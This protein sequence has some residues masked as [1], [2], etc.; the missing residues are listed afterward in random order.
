MQND[1]DLLY[2]KEMESVCF[3]DEPW[4]VDS[5]KST[6]QRKDVFYKLFYD[7]TDTPIGYFI[8]SAM[9]EEAELY[10]IAVIPSKRGKGYGKKLMELFLKSCPK[11]TEKVFLEVRES[12]AAAIGL[13]ESFGFKLSGRRRNYYRGEDALNYLLAL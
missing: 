12:N 5:I 2:I 11:N 3:P 1:K 7:E 9:F 13:Y 4:S 6:L 10:R 8:A